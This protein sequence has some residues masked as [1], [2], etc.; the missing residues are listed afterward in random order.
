MEWGGYIMKRC[1]TWE[2]ETFPKRP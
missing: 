1:E 2:V